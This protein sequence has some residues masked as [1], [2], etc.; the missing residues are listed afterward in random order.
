MCLTYALQFLEEIENSGM[1]WENIN[2]TPDN[3]K[4]QSLKKYGLTISYVNG[5][6][7]ALKKKGQYVKAESF[8]ETIKRDWSVLGIEYKKELIIEK[9][10]DLDLDYVNGVA[11]EI[12]QERKSQLCCKNNQS[13]K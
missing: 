1:R 11:D 2:Q 6:N 8:L 3:L 10:L 9:R 7:D 5:V 4:T 12:R 13:E